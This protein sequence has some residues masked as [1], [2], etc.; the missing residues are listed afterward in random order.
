MSESWHD[1]VRPFGDVQPSTDLL[2]GILEREASLPTERRSRPRLPRAAGWALA[3]VGV[4]MVLGVLAL[5]AHS[6]GNA[7][8]SAPEGGVTTVMLVGQQGRWDTNHVAAWR[9]LQRARVTCGANPA[10]RGASGNNGVRPSDLCRALA[11][12]PAHITDSRCSYTSIIGPLMPRRVVITGSIGGTPVHL[13]MGMICNPPAELANMHGLIYTAAFGYDNAVKA[14]I[15]ESTF[16]KLT[17]IAKSEAQNLGDPRLHSAE[18]VLTTRR[19]MNQGLDYGYQAA[20]QQDAKV[21]VIQ[22]RGTFTCTECSHPPGASPPTGTAAQDVLSFGSLTP[23]DFG[24]T[25]H[26]VVMQRMGPV[27]HLTWR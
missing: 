11:Y 10:I 2:P 21:F 18:L 23:S 9:T 12:Y 19:R 5:A 24:L 4:V 27:M 1:L 22:L 7:P 25:T 8:T 3:A 13:D 17:Q 14:S 6:R 26:P 16:R 15:S 20:E